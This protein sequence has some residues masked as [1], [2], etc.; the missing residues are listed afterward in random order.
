LLYFCN[1]SFGFRSFPGIYR[2]F[3]P[4]VLPVFQTIKRLQSGTVNLFLP[5]KIYS[6]GLGQEN[7]TG[8]F[9]R[10]PELLSCKEINFSGIVSIWDVTV[11]EQRK[12]G[13]RVDVKVT[14]G[15]V[16]V[17]VTV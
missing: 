11:V 1:S 5:K 2:T 6:D 12:M 15:A 14:E 3:T 16:Q 17:D 7:H 8:F 9:R 13:S 10:I 4:Q